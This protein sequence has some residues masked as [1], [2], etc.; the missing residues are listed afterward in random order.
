MSGTRVQHAGTRE[1]P[2]MEL[3]APAYDPASHAPGRRPVSVLVRTKN[4]EVNIGDCLRALAFSDDVI[5]LDS[6]STD[7]TLEIVRAMPGVRLI[8]KTFRNESEQFNWILDNIRLRHGWLYL[9]DADERVSPELADELTTVTNDPGRPHVAYRVRYK[10][11]F[12]GRWV[13]RG[14]MYPVWIIRLFR[15]DKIRYEDR[16]INVHPIVHGSLG[17]LREHFVHY[18]FNKGLTPWFNKHNSYSD[19]EAREAVRV[20]Q[21][22]AFGAR[23]RQLFSRRPGVAR[24][25]LKDL[26]FYLRLRALARF[27]YMY[28]VRLGLLDGKAGFHYAAMISMYE[29]WIEIKILEQR[30]SWR[31]RTEAKVAAML[32][33]MP[34]AQRPR[35]GEGRA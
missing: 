20:I 21:S 8:Q 22:G 19:M 29:Y 27:L 26:S 28:F 10:N 18:S 17:D 25:A 30:K 14:G 33:D 13:K 32:R 3:E 6:F 2:W 16:S 34:G 23:V 7:R 35:P 12:M 11:M 15:P 31:D 4:E 24:R 5:V 1:D 9:C